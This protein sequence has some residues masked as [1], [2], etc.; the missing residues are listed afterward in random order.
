[1]YGSG[2]EGFFIVALHV[3]LGDEKLSISV[4]RRGDWRFGLA[5]MLE[6]SELMAMISSVELTWHTI[7]HKISPS[8]VTKNYI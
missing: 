7:F 2:A 6:K 4:K 5:S 8:I 3:V 1:M